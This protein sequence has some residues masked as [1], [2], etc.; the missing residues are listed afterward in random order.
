MLQDQSVVTPGFVVKT[1][2]TI[3]YGIFKVF[4]MITCMKLVKVGNAFS[5]LV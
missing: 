4:L 2:I 5:K 3:D 1:M